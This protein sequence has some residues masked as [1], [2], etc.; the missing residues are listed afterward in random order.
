MLVLDTNVDDDLGVTVEGFV[1]F[2]AKFG[3][4]KGHRAVKITKAIQDIGKV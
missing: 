2:K 3:L 1:K 4:F